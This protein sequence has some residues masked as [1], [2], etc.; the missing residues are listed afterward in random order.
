M[1]VQVRRNSGL[2]HAH[3]AHGLVGWG[4]RPGMQAGK[5]PRTS[6]GK[7]DPPWERA[8]SF[9]ELPLQ[10]PIR[11]IRERKSGAKGIPRPPTIL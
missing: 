5:L 7:G 8:R 11:D 9:S 3:G 6:D 1:R 10:V 2:A 4:A